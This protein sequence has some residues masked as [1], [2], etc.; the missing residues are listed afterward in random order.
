[1]ATLLVRGCLYGAPLALDVQPHHVVLD[2]CAAPGSKTTQM[3]EII[4]QSLLASPD[5]HN[6]GLVVAN[7]ADMTGLICWYTR[8]AE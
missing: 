1:M 7:D 4:D 3:M 5:E 8:P 6:N 2:M